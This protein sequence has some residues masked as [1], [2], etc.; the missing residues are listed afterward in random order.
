MTEL[1]TGTDRHRE[2][3]GQLATLSHNRV[4]DGLAGG[5]REG[6]E[7]GPTLGR[8]KCAQLL[9]TIPDLIFETD[10]TGRWTFANQ[11]WFDVTGQIPDAFDGVTAAA[12]I[13]GAD[14]EGF[15]Q[16]MCAVLSGDSP[17]ARRDIRLQTG[18]GE[19]IWAD[20]TLL[21]MAA[22]S[23]RVTGVL[24]RI[25]DIDAR[26]RAEI[27]Q[28]Q[29]GR[30]AELRADASV[31]FARAASLSEVAQRCAR[32]MVR[33]MS[34]RLARVWLLHQS[35]GGLALTGSAGLFEHLNGARELLPW[36]SVQN[37]AT[38]RA[39]IFDPQSEKDVAWACSVGIEEV[40]VAPVLVEETIVGAVASFAGHALTP[41]DRDTVDFI[42]AG[43]GYQIERRNSEEKFRTL[44]ELG[45]EAR[46]VLDSGRVQDCNQAAV[47]LLGA[48]SKADLVNRDASAFWPADG[49]GL[50]FAALE[51]K[52][53]ELGYATA[54]QTLR[55]LSGEMVPVRL[56]LSPAAFGHRTAVLATFR[57][58]QELKTVQAALAEAEDSAQTVTRIKSELM[59]TVSQEFR[60]PLNAVLS[61]TQQLIDGSLSWNQRELVSSVRAS[62][63]RLMTLA[64]DMLDL[65]F[66]EA[67]GI[68][69]ESI[70]F[71]VEAMLEEALET[72]AEEARSKGLELHVR[73]DAALP[74]RLVSDPQRLRQVLIQMGRNAIRHTK[75]GYVLVDV[76]WTEDAAGARSLRLAVEDTSPGIQSAQAVLLRQ[77]LHEH[78][79][80]A[81]R[82]RGAAGSGLTSAQHIAARLGS[83]IHFE[84][85]DQG[86]VC[87][88]TSLRVELPPDSIQPA[89]PASDG[90]PVLVV[91]ED[92]FSA[93]VLAE[94]LKGMGMEPHVF[95]SLEALSDFAGGGGLQVTGFR[96][97]LAEQS[98]EIETDRELL[99]VL[100]A[101]PVIGL[102]A[103]RSAERRPA[104]CYGNLV[105]GPFLPGKLARALKPIGSSAV[106]SQRQRPAA[107]EAVTVLVVDDHPA[108]RAVAAGLAKRLGCTVE[109]AANGAE[110][111]ERCRQR[112]FDLIFMDCQMPVMDGFEATAEIRRLP[113]SQMTP[114][115]ALTASSVASDRERAMRLGMNGFL[116]KPISL[117]AVRQSVDYWTAAA[118][119]GSQGVFD[120]DAMLARMG[121]DSRIAASVAATFTAEAP[122]MLRR[123][124]EAMEERQA[125]ALIGAALRLRSSGNLFAAPGL[126]RACDALAS[127]IELHDWRAGESLRTEVA[128][129]TVRLSAWLQSQFAGV[130]GGRNS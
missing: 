2:A 81:A 119:S 38:L 121:G 113:G 129:E 45:S 58:I 28:A 53:L 47:S 79:F 103:S 18:S 60:A 3:D 15:A 64:N 105:Q 24:G 4:P 97:V 77:L 8:R 36:A 10:Q 44:F 7:E 117:D 1:Q 30:L 5:P 73:W 93:S 125:G 94:C 111:V 109:T 95:R 59:T 55:T 51:A 124:D 110:A 63:Q 43:V 83:G 72:L 101:L 12:A 69:L 11:T 92:E 115:L 112:G 66:W 85:R 107:E 128:A 89:S 102:Q 33:Y 42:A 130:R 108:N 127:A 86:G 20:V 41:A 106:A 123:L 116:S 126:C 56:S 46:L 82:T 68:T 75:E 35:R 84:N 91:M 98:L 57:S 25:S 27:V 96:A 54:E 34:A 32:A 16:S 6:V 87:F 13:H 49:R 67:G 80:A 9:R 70:P 118:R 122:R 40:Y 22:E 99:A 120:L 90:G 19:W 21:P 76:S 31:S 37:T 17:R 114:I 104:A 50:P 88:W 78:D 65:A 14:R 71:S 26:K 74:A 39:A 100:G 52:A 29:Q 61:G 62:A 48:A 23:G